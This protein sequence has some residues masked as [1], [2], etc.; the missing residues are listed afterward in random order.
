MADKFEQKIYIDLICYPLYSLGPKKRVGVWFQGCNIGCSGCISKY[1][2]NQTEDKLKSIDEVIDKIKSADTNRLTISGGEPFMQADALFL[3][4]KNV[5]DKFDD[6]LV[7]SGYKYEY[8]NSKYSD[9]LD[10]IDVLIDGEYIE[11][12]ATN[13]GYKGSSNQRVIMF[14]KD[15]LDDYCDYLAN[16]VHKMQVH[17]TK[18]D[19]YLLGIPKKDDIQKIKSIV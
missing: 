2:W 14:N 15:L 4:L 17:T 3:L 16:P 1:T 18:S 12:L 7:Y 13:S 6:I 8:L 5:R 10:L 11:S 9:I 19:L